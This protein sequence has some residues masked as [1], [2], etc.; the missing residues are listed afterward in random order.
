MIRVLFLA[1]ILCCLGCTAKPATI[2]VSELEIVAEPFDQWLNQDFTPADPLTP[3]HADDEGQ[4]SWTGWNK[5]WF[6]SA[7]GGQVGDVV[8]TNAA[9]N[10]GCQ[11]GNPLFGADPETGTIVLAKAGLL[12]LSYWVTEYL[13]AD[14]PDQIKLRNW[15]YGAQAV[16]GFAATGWNAAQDCR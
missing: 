14:S 12:G 5:F 7:I 4:S 10:R 6:A 3:Y 11:E 8:S 2:S 1:V 16:T 13:Y 15:I 9:I